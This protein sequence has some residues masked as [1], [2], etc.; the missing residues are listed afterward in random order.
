MTSREFVRRFN[1]IQERT[2]SKLVAEIQTDDLVYIY[3]IRNGKKDL[4]AYSTY[5]AHWAFAPREDRVLVTPKTL[6]LMAK[7]MNYPIKD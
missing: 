4:F 6:K 2:C 5:Y 1:K 3:R 7:Y